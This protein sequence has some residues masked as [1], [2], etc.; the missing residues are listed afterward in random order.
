MCCCGCL[1]VDPHPPVIPGDRRPFAGGRSGIQRKKRRSHILLR[2]PLF[3]RGIR[4]LPARTSH[5]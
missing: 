3:F 2:L 4:Y 1:L 5:S